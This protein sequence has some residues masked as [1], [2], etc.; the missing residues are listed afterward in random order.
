MQFPFLGILVFDQLI[1]FSILDR[2]GIGLHGG[3]KH[4]GYEYFF[5]EISIAVENEKFIGIALPTVGHDIDKIMSHYAEDFEMNSPVIKELMNEPAGK[6]KGKNQVR[7]YWEKALK[8]NP[9]LH[10]EIIN[11]FTG[12]NSVVIHYKGHRGLS[13]EVFIFNEEGKVITS[14]AHYV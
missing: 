14:Y 1:E 10:F 2:E 6:I 12:A 8:H 5:Q 11:V 4:K 9:Y 3:L 7:R 13:A